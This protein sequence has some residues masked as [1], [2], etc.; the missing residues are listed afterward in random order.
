MTIARAFGIAIVFGAVGASLSAQTP[1]TPRSSTTSSPGSTTAAQ[2]AARARLGRPVSNQEIAEAL[3]NSG[4]SPDQVRARLRAGGYDT[5]LA[6]PYL[7]PGGMTAQGGTQGSAGFVQALRT[8]GI[9]TAEVGTTTTQQQNDVVDEDADT[10]AVA[11]GGV[12]GKNVFRRGTSAFDPIAG[13]PVDGSYRLGVGD[14][15]QMII[16]GDVEEAYQLDIRRDGTVVV[17]RIGQISLAGL[18]L[19]GARTLLRSRAARSYV[20]LATGG[21]KLDLTLS[22]L[23]TNSVFLIGEVELPGAYQVSALSSAFHALVRAGGPTVR[24]SFRDV[25]VRRSG[26]VVAN[27]DLYEYLLDGNAGNDIRLEQGDA[28]FVPL[29]TRSVTVKGAVR[30]PGVFELKGAEDLTDLLRFTGGVTSNASTERIQIDRILPPA[31]RSPGVERAVVDIS[32]GQDLAHLPVT[33]L[34]DGDV[35]TVFTVGERRRN[36]VT[37]KGEVNQ[38]GTFELRDGTTLSQLLDRAQGFQP[39]ALTDR[40]KV[41]RPIAQTGRREIFSVDMST[42]S[43]RSFAVREYDEVTVLDGRL[44]YPAGR[45]T[46]SGA[47]VKSGMQPYAQGQTLKDV[48]DQAGGLRPEA[49][50]VEVFR[51]RNTQEFSDTTSQS[52]HFEVGSGRNDVVSA[53]RFAMQPEDYVVVRGAPG[54]RQQRFVQMT[55][56]FS[57]PG[58]YA[59]VEFRDRVTDLVARAGGL[60]PNASAH[61]FRLMRNGRSV[62]ISLDRALDGDESQNPTLLASD[63]LFVGPNIQT[64]FVAGEVEHPTLVLYRPGMSVDE[65]LAKAGGP[66]TTADVKRA[67]IESPT[68]D[69]RRVN[70]GRFR[71]S[72]EVIA[73]S[74]ITVPAKPVDTGSGWAQTLT[75][76]LQ[77]VT[78]ITSLVLAYLAVRQ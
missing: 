44:A 77:I 30:R 4:L 22:R 17:P 72:P 37:L 13:G 14:Q 9:L 65:Y 67:Y 51:R 2:D 59:I 43:A 24:G 41:S 66:K 5:T 58:Q 53:A 19:E 57:Y 60:L 39:W 29:N 34:F 68:G 3:R 48:I 75:Q 28:I 63:E 1:Q 33:P 71:P 7:R 31:R 18:T 64:V 10:L 26:Q 49:Q 40:V 54:F 74:T 12:F 27:L 55:G 32:L 76:T 16:T 50:Y 73:G 36:T 46:V 42:D 11:T 6:D 62:A 15:L 23:R 45:I 21:A 52:F 56:L 70:T 78:G 8:L 69:I 47:L 38:P 20:S 35:V 25:Q 61:N